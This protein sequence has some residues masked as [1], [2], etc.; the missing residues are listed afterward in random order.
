MF[1]INL[2]CLNWTYIGPF[3][4]CCLQTHLRLVPLGTT[5]LK[6]KERWTHIYIYIM[7]F[8]IDLHYMGFVFLK[9]S[10]HVF[11]RFLTL[12]I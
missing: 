2:L 9:C 10:W 3:C 11:L 8:I 1:C 4:K 7:I 6:F 12:I 5:S